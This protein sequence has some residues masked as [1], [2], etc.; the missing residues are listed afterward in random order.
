[1]RS[2]HTTTKSSPC[3]LQIEKARAQQQRPNTAKSKIKIKN[4]NKKKKKRI[5][6]N[7]KKTG[8][9]FGLL[10]KRKR[11]GEKQGKVKKQR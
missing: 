3:S 9:N 8:Q 11:Q 6:D 7:L 4:N 2:L 10:E 5:Y 1:M